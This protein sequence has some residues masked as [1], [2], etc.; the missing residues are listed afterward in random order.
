MSFLSCLSFVFYRVG[1]L[2]KDTF[3]I[4]TKILQ[5]MFKVYPNF[6]IY[7]LL[8]ISRLTWKPKIKQFGFSEKNAHRSRRNKIVS[9]FL[10]LKAKK[11]TFL[12]M[13]SILLYGIFKAFQG[14]LNW[15]EVY[16]GLFY[17][18]RVLKIWQARY[19]QKGNFLIFLIWAHYLYTSN[20]FWRI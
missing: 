10:L 9:I 16:S 5:K 4:T 19:L 1:R 17:K 18:Q 7:L 8:I 6:R 13:I 3:L 11:R 12:Y 2:S 15:A 20:A 14:N